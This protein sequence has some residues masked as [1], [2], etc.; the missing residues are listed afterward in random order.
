MLPDLMSPCSATPPSPE[1][2]RQ[3]WAGV[4]LPM[5][6]LLGVPVGVCS[7]DTRGRQ[8]FPMGE[9]SCLGSLPCCGQPSSKEKGLHSA[10]RAGEA[11]GGHERKGWMQTYSKEESSQG[12]VVLA[13]GSVSP[14]APAVG[15]KVHNGL[16]WQASPCPSCPPHTCLYVGPPG[17]PGL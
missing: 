3:T 16:C 13:P 15:V 5:C 11:G 6:E 14:P 2:T 7:E 1:E 12:E 8:W 9:C 10:V 4:I 17:A